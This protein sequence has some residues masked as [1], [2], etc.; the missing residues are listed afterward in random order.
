MSAPTPTDDPLPLARGGSV[1]APGA[2]PLRADA[3]AQFDALLHDL[4]PEA[5]RVDADRIQHLCTWL[6]GLPA[7]AARD[8]LARRLGRLDELR[9]M[10][11]D[12]DWDPRESVRTRLRQLFAYIDQSDDLIPDRE[13]LLGKLDDVLL[14]ELAWPAFASEAEDYRDF[15]TYRDETHPGGNGE[16]QRAAWMRDRLAEIALLQHQL[17]VH[18]SHYVHR[19]HPEQL[20]HVL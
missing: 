2:M 15:C 6:A 20:F 11:D 17:R 14:I 18:D 19:G 5:P 8:V 1:P 9:A 7:H 10:L 12:R 13:P 4:W 16:S 3:V